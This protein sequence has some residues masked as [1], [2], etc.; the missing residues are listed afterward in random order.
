MHDEEKFKLFLTRRYDIQLKSYKSYNKKI[1]KLYDLTEDE[2]YWL[3][4]LIYMYIKLNLEV[5][6]FRIVQKVRGILIITSF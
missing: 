3:K 1:Q 6:I 5:A 4:Q 2:K